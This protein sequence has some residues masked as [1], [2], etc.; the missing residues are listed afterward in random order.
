MCRLPKDD[1]VIFSSRT[2]PGNEKAVANVV[3]GLVRQ[4]VHVL[5]DQTHL[6]HVSGHPRVDEIAEL[7]NVVKP[8]ALIPV[9]GE[10]YHLQAHAELGVKLGIKDVKIVEDRAMVRL[11]GGPL[12]VVDEVPGGRLYK[13]G[14]LLLPEEDSTLAERR[15]LLWAGIVSVA[16][17]VTNKGDL[18][19]DIEISLTGVP[20]E[21]T[22]GDDMMD[23]VEDSVRETF[24]SLPK[25]KRRNFETLRE[26]LIRSVR[27]GVEQEWGKKPW[28]EVHLL[29]I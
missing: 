26:A 11:T 27:G 13:D 21:G 20:K 4:G 25:P 28:V 8:K 10:P 17:C 23:I 3:N 19:S 5:N 7:Y 1:L 18:A 22:S 24:H 14:N 2:I 6:V 9:H 29:E 16:A 15:R 12:K